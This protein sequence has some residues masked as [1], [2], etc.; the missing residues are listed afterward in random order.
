MTILC[1]LA[2]IY[3]QLALREESDR[4]LQEI[5]QVQRD[6]RLVEHP[7]KRLELALA[8]A[9]LRLVVAPGPEVFAALQS[10]RAEAEQAGI[11]QVATEASQ[12]LTRHQNRNQQGGSHAP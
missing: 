10:L 5:T 9:R 6:A 1:V 7:T 8:S 3:A 12:L 2:R 11:L 4:C